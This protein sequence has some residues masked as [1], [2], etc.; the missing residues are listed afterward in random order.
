MTD[1][2]ILAHFSMRT[3]GLSTDLST[4]PPEMMQ[5]E[6]TMES[7]AVPCSVNFAPG[8]CDWLVQM[9]HF[10]LYRSKSGTTE[11]LSLIH[12]SEPTRRTPISYAVF[13]LKKKKI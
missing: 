11:T 6:P 5:P 3:L 9:G 2:S 12:I 10:R 8:T 7:S 13:C 4:S 1:S